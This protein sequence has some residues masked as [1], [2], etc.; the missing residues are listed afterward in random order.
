MSQTIHYQLFAQYNQWMNAKL[1]EVCDKIS[2]DERKKDRGAFF[3]SIHMTLNHL[4]W[5]DRTWLGRF[6]GK[7]YQQG[8]LGEELYSDF[9]ALRAERER[10]DL[11]IIAWAA[12][13]KEEWLSSTVTFRSA[14]YNRDFS[15]PAIVAVAQMFNHQT[16]HRG[17][18]TT[19]LSQ[20]GIDYGA[21]DIPVMPGLEKF[22]NK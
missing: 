11:E 13:L 5:A 1:Y 3:K 20:M 19:L 16:H 10:I 18:L 22:Q 12:S 21:T 2:D 9:D 7:V 8:K 17:Q 4:L 14:S 15:L 6:N